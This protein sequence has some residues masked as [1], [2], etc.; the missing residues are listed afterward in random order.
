MKF[1]A[2]S[3][4]GN[5]RVE[6]P[7]SHEPKSRYVPFRRFKATGYVYIIFENDIAVK[8]LLENCSQEFGGA[9]EWYFKLNARRANTKELRQV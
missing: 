4:Y 5:C 6:W 1:K 3:N 7:G 2:F 9:G 8:R